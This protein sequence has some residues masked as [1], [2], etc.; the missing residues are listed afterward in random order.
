MID[1]K[2]F[3]ELVAQMRAAQKKYFKA[4]NQSNLV[5][6][7]ELERQ[8]DKALHGEIILR[9]DHN[10]QPELFSPRNKGVGDQ[11]PIQE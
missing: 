8:V 1:V 11:I 2:D 3:C 7:K 6:A 10:Q 4:R 5:A 9:V